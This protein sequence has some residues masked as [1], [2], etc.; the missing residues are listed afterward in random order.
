MPE[1]YADLYFCTKFECL[2]AGLSKTNMFVGKHGTAKGAGE[3]HIF[4]LNDYTY[5]MHNNFSTIYTY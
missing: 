3:K 1:S 2:K 4:V 5:D